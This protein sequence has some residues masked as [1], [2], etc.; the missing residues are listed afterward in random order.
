MRTEDVYPPSTQSRAAKILQYNKYVALIKSNWCLVEEVHSVM[1]K[2][3]QWTQVLS[4]ESI[5]VSSK[6]L[7]LVNDLNAEVRKLENRAKVT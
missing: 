1:T 3:A 4:S 6:V 5:V 7:I 2:C